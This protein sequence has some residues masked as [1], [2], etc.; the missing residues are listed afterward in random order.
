MAFDLPVALRPVWRFAVHVVV[1]SF[2]FLIVYMMAV[3]VDTWVDWTAT[4]GAHAW[5]VN[6][7]RWVGAVIFWL[8]IFGLSLFLGKE[9]IKLARHIVLRDWED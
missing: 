2:A 4:H 9:T 3:G 6:E 8:D 5:M 7:A 1:G